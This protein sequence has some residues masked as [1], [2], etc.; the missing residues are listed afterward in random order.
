MVRARRAAVGGRMRELRKQAGLTQEAV[1]GAAGLIRQFYLVVEAGQRTLSLDNVFPIADALSADPRE[2]STELPPGGLGPVRVSPAWPAAR[3]IRYVK[4]DDWRPEYP[5]L[6][7][8][9][10]AGALSVVTLNRTRHRRFR[11]CRRFPGSM[12]VTGS[13]LWLSR[14]LRSS[15]SAAHSAIAVN[16]RAPASTAHTASA[17]RCRTPRRARGSATAAST[18]RTVARSPSRP[19]AAAN[20]WRNTGS[21][22]DDDAAGMVPRSDQAGVRTAMI[23]SWAMPVPLPAHTGVS[24]VLSPARLCRPAGRLVLSNSPS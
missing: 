1:A 2:L 7:G 5:G 17:R 15:V 20:R 4:L 11:L 13:A 24:P 19:S 22:G 21:T 14:A 3:G 16:D 18:D 6:L 8:G 12:T 9:P 23:N 10:R